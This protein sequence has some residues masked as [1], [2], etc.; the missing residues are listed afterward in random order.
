MRILQMKTLADRAARQLLLNR[1]NRLEPRDSGRWGRMSSHQM[2]CHLSDAFRVAMGE[3]E[4]SMATGV[5]QRTLLKWAALYVPVPWP[6]GFPITP[7]LRQGVGG[8][9]PVDFERD[10]A[11]LARLIDRFGQS[12]RDFEWQVHPVFG[13][14]RDS[15]WL[16]WGFMH[17]DHH[18]RQFGA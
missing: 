11:D 16:R 14:M 8:T 15:Q 3:K 7:E 5:L 9:P 1:L 10:R 2:I 17:V 6:K 4:T 13:R 12:H 18:L